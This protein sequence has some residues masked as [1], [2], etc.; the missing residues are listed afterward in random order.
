MKVE[1]A[2]IDKTIKTALEEDLAR[3]GDI[4][5]EAILPPS[6]HAKAEIVSKD[7]GVIAGIDIAARVFF[8]IDAGLSVVLE[9]RDGEAVK[10]GQLIAIIDGKAQ[11]ILAAERT[12]LNFLQH[13]SGIATLTSRFVEKV[14]QHPVKILD[15]RKTTPGLRSMEKYAVTVG[16][17][18][19]HRFGLYDAVLIKENHVMAVGGCKQ[20]ISLVRESLGYD[21]KIEVE[22]EDMEQFREAL[23]AKPDIIMLDNMSL[24]SMREAVKLSQGKVILEA[25]GGVTLDNVLEVAE[26]GVDFISTSELTQSALSLDMSLEIVGQ[27]KQDNC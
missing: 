11:S 5:S 26:T 10:P 2:T 7:N 27:N 1:Q 16:G 3:E 25:S 13:L 8:L 4:T 22:T 12:A 24:E 14:K 23:E 17:G 6:F 20:A 9:V 15:T 18:Q 19:N 21:V